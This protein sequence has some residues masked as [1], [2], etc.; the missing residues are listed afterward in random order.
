M[1]AQFR[2]V[3]ALMLAFVLPAAT[4]A[5]PSLSL[6]LFTA[7]YRGDVATVTDL[8]AAG[9]DPNMKV[10]GIT[11]LHIGARLGDTP[12]IEAL[13]AASANP[14]A[15]N[16]TKVLFESPYGG[17]SPLH[18]A[19]Y[20]GHG[21]AIAALLA[22]GANV[23]VKT[24]S[25]STPLHYAANAGYISAANVLLAGGADPNART[26][27]GETPLLHAACAL[28]MAAKHTPERISERHY[29]S[30][31]DALLRNGADPDVKV[32]AKLLDVPKDYVC[33]Y[34]AA[35]LDVLVDALE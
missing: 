30:V 33:P 34:G 22:G 4:V 13:L 20:S 28:W 32:K 15:K 7:V 10:R 23:D 3:F 35:P 1:R 2:P 9:A 18:V 17:E 29:L 5:D 11:P 12:S 27:D 14:N 6:H 24:S 8:L 25:N 19:A 31:I 26:D 16:E 21:D